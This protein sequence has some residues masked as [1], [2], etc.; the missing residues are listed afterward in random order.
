MLLTFCP[1]ALTI[2]NEIVEVVLERI[3]KLADIGA[4]LSG[5]WPSGLQDFR[6]SGLK[7]GKVSMLCFAVWAPPQ[8]TIMFTLELCMT[9]AA[10]VHGTCLLRRRVLMVKNTVPTAARCVAA[11]RSGRRSPLKKN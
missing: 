8:V 3:R 1:F 10:G 11:L 4:G 9:F 5:F 7:F 6:A 2:G